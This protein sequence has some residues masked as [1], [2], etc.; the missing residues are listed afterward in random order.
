[1]RH[2]SWFFCTDV[3]FEGLQ[4]EVRNNLDEKLKEWDTSAQELKFKSEEY[5]A[6]PIMAEKLEEGVDR[7]NILN[8]PSMDQ[9]LEE[10][11]GALVTVYGDAG[12]GKTAMLRH[13]AGLWQKNQKD[14]KIARLYDLVFCLPLRHRRPAKSIVDVICQME[15][16]PQKYKGRLEQVLD[17]PAKKALFLLDSF[18]EVPQKDVTEDLKRILRREEYVTQTVVV[19]SRPGSKLSELQQDITPRIVAHLQVL[20]KD[21]ITQYIQKW[22][23]PRDAEE[24]IEDLGI[25]FLQRPINLSLTCSLWSKLIKDERSAGIELRTRTQLFSRLLQYYIQVYVEKKNI[26]EGREFVPTTGSPLKNRDIPRDV[27]RFVKGVGDLCMEAIFNEEETQWL[28]IEDHDD[29]DKVDLE[30]FGLFTNGPENNLV[31]V[32]HLLFMEYLA[33]M[34]IVAD[35]R[36]LKMVFAKIKQKCEDSQKASKSNTPTQCLEDVLSSLAPGLPNVI[37]FMVGLGLATESLQE[38]CKLFVIKEHRSLIAYQFQMQYELDLL[39]ECID[40]SRQCIIATALLSASPA[41]GTNRDLYIVVENRGAHRLLEFGNRDQHLAFLQKMYRCEFRDECGSPALYHTNDEI[42]EQYVWDSYALHCVERYNLAVQMRNVRTFHSEVPVSL[43]PRLASGVGFLDVQHCSLVWKDLTQTPVEVTS[44]P[45]RHK[46][47]VVMSE[48]KGLGEL[49]HVR[50]PWVYA[51]RLSSC[52]VDLS[53]V[54]MSCTELEELEMGDCRMLLGDTT[55]SLH[56][57]RTVTLDGASHVEKAGKWLREGDAKQ[58]L[59]ELGPSADVDIWNY[60]VSNNSDISVAPA[61]LTYCT[62]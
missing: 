36:A 15:L 39:E 19:T 11:L 35:K 22:N 48:V 46:M 49:R 47:E 53:A 20:P 3:T 21:Q 44:S 50:L 16:V 5:C 38:L 12:L 13:I 18:E 28:D 31:G 32:P 30:E 6:Q 23:L 10:N 61:T 56:A 34:Y 59:Q 25:A 57:L 42:Y 55:H 26:E 41:I 2:A 24:S 9:L 33:A 45:T 29:I 7:P 40:A 52:D 4:R 14:D 62:K 27:I 51:L 37:K 60:K 17:M 58:A 43:L 54:A 8:T 1:M